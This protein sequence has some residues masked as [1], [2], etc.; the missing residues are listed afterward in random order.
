VN[1]PTCGHPLR[2]HNN[3]LISCDECGISWM[4]AVPTVAEVEGALRVRDELVAQGYWIINDTLF[5]QGG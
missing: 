1:C 4:S 5:G 3:P 2:Y